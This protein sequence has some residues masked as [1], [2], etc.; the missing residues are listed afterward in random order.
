MVLEGHLWSH[1]SRIV[2]GGW[3]MGT[4]KDWWK[5]FETFNFSRNSCGI[6]LVNNILTEGSYSEEE[7]ISDQYGIASPYHDKKILP[8]VVIT[9]PVSRARPMQLS[10]FCLSFS[11]HPE[12]L[13]FKQSSLDHFSWNLAVSTTWVGTLSNYGWIKI[14]N[15]ISV[16]SSPKPYFWHSTSI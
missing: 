1:D 9:L 15:T 13:Q 3:R 6:F 12:P 2:V 5:S 16:A 11:Y 8:V 7:H 14:N 4:I 10:H